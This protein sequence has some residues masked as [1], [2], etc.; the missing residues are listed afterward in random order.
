[1]V[2]I[3]SLGLKKG[4]I[5][6]LTEEDFPLD[7]P[8]NKSAEALIGMAID[9]H[10]KKLLAPKEIEVPDCKYE[11]YDFKFEDEYFDIKS[12]S[13]KSVTVSQR[14][15]DFAVRRM[16]TG[17]DV[18]YLVFEQLSDFEF[19]YVG[20]TS[21]MYLDS[22]NSIRHSQFDNGGVYFYSSMKYS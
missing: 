11:V 10:I 20:Y 22:R 17:G 8:K 18:F 21:A 19:E 13:S 6:Q 3:E 7:F 15:W 16:H 1:M 2:N 4:D 12:F 5:F 14:E 9:G